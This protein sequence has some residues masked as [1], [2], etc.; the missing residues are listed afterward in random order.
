MLKY[1]SKVAGVN[2]P[3]NVLA[4]TNDAGTTMYSLG[5]LRWGLYTDIEARAEDY[6]FPFFWRKGKLLR[7]YIR[8]YLDGDLDPV[9]ARQLELS[10][11]PPVSSDDVKAEAKLETERKEKLKQLKAQHSASFSFYGSNRNRTASKEIK[12]PTSK[13]DL[14]IKELKNH[15][16]INT[17]EIFFDVNHSDRGHSVKVSLERPLTNGNLSFTMKFLKI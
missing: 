11:A 5:G 2:R 12:V 7:S 3:A 6:T 13:F 9:K 15:E 8:S 14:Q 17:N 10:S 1:P 4:L 16:T